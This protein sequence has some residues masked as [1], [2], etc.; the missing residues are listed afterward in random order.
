MNDLENSFFK[1]LGRQPTEAERQ[2]LYLVRDALGLK[3]NDALWLILMAL[4]YHQTMYASF[5]A[6]IT[7]GAT[8]TLH[9][10]KQ[11]ADAT[12]E[13]T[14][15][16]AKADL[17]EAVSSVAQNVARLVAARR[18]AIWIAICVV[19]SVGS[20]STFGWYIHGEAYK[21][22]Y[23][24][25]YGRAYIDAKEEK[26]AAA[27]ANTPQGKAAYRLAQSGSID[28]L[29][30]CEAPGWKKEQGYCYVHPSATGQIYG[31]KLR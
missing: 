18:A 6:L 27:W 21:A 17:A 4:Q 14:K 29:I 20:F 12:L 16:S 2:Q 10:F 30:K 8:E 5:P 26:A 25:G 7:Q 31:W 9:E 11:T 23:N 28:L 24:L 19:L 15:E 22:G 13:A 3:N 1:L